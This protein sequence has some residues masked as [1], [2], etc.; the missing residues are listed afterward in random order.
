MAEPQNSRES[1]KPG[2]VMSVAL[3]RPCPK[4][5]V[6][7]NSHICL[8]KG[9]ANPI[10]FGKGIELKAG[11][12]HSLNW[13]RETRKKRKNRERIRERVRREPGL[14]SGHRDSCLTSLARLGL[15]P[16]NNR[17]VA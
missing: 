5:Q 1:R 2:T 9:S 12:C 10:A 14:L 15:A 13:L 6:Q 11:K 4:E 3:G 17:I 8:Y 16:C 7:R